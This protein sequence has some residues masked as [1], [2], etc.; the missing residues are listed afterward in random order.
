MQNLWK[1]QNTISKVWK[2]NLSWRTRSE[3]YEKY[4][5]YPN[6]MDKCFQ[7]AYRINPKY[8]RMQRNLRRVETFALS[9]RNLNNR[10]IRFYLFAD[11]FIHTISFFYH[12]IED[13]FI[14]DSS[15]FYI[16]CSLH[17]LAYIKLFRNM[18]FTFN[19]YVG[20]LNYFLWELRTLLGS[21]CVCQQR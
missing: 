10:M 20:T 16:N 3:F 7:N 15:M 18:Y 5:Q 4:Q 8:M 11:I 17:M 9:C 19:I 12:N 13:G 2:H 21:C 14:Y 1:L 6:C